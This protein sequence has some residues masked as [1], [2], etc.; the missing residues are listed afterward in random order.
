MTSIVNLVACPEDKQPL[1]EKTGTLE[2]TACHKTY[3]IVNGIPRFVPIS[4]YAESFGFEWE[5]FNKTQ[6]DSFNSVGQ[7]EERVRKGM[8]WSEA[9]VKDKLVLDVGC[10]SGRF[11]EI[12]ARWGV[13]QVVGLDYSTA[14]EVAKKNT[15]ELGFT[16]CSFVQGDALKLPFN[17]GVFDA[18]FSIG[19]IQHTA[20]PLQALREICRVTKPGGVIG[21]HGVYVRSLKKLIHPKYILRPI[22]KRL[23]TKMLFTAVKK[24]VTFALPISRFLRN[25]LHWRQGL[26]ERLTAVANYEGAVPGINETNVFDWA[27]LDTFDWFSPTYDNPLTLREIEDTLRASEAK[28]IQHVDPLKKSIDYRAIK[29]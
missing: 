3:S 19:V 22:T 4:N 17:D 12:M 10:G 11:T 27:F 15:S 21:L 2:C 26:V 6:V 25:K 7:S 16:T 29:A 18:V 13:K 1:I 23:P 5:V 20:D 9:D 8:G 24:W 28:E 14:V